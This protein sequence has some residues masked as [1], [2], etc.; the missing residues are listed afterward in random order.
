MP[1]HRAHKTYS[2]WRWLPA[3]AALVLLGSSAVVFTT[4]YGGPEALPAGACP[5][6]RV[7]T[8]RSFAPVQPAAAL[9]PVKPGRNRGEL[10]HRF[11]ECD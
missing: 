8:A 1:Q 4:R 11:L 2:R 3:V 5:T 6:L 10:T 9:Q 7:V